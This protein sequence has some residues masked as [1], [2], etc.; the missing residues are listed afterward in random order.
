MFGIGM[1]ELIVIA[2]V[3]LL[4]VGPKKLPD[5]AK[6]L[7]KGFTEFRKAVDGVSDS[8][9][10]TIKADELKQEVDS[11]KDSLLYKKNGENGGETPT[12]PAEKGTPDSQPK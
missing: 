2:V 10:E 8:V 5:L 11:V 3:A 6:S 7:G 9:K 1:P 4:V 12:P